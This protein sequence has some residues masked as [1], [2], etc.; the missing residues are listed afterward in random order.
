M[1]RIVKWESPSNIA[2]VK[3]WGK[4]GVQ[5]PN[6]PSISFTLNNS[7]S[8]TS[9]E[10][11]AKQA[12]KVE[13]FFE[14]KLNKDFGL[15]IEKYLNNI[16]AELPFINDYSFIIR[17]TNTFPHS[18]GIASSAS[19]FS[20]LA[21]CLIDFDSQINNT[22]LSFEK[23][24]YFARLGSGS[25]C[26]SVYG[27][28]A[29]WGKS[30]DIDN[31]ANE[32]AIS[33]N[34]EI[35][36]VFKTYHDDIVIV[37]ADKKSVSSSAGHKLMDTNPYSTEKYNQAYVNTKLLYSSLKSNDIQEFIRIVELE[38]LSLHSMMMISNPSFILIKPETLNIINK[39]REFRNDTNI[40]VCFTLDAGPNIHILYPD[41]N[42]TEVQKF[43]SS[44]MNKFRIIN[45]FVGSGA[46]KL[47]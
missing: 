39:I 26:R 47:K 37:D 36:P 12:K 4:H 7:K 32:F 43:I 42:K 31:S 11:I 41:K 33:L 2:L 27:G 23:A 10:L 35:N 3:Y 16:S 44:E 45:D 19:A 9:V 1:I 22:E 20:A 14:N 6:N 40:P 38:A 8:I 28:V 34:N 18:T 17:S 30:Q 5:L 25:A 24:S 46:L 15:R 13:F 29:M 21:M